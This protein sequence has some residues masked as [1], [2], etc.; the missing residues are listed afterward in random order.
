MNN[1]D[2][3]VKQAIK[4]SQSA[5]EDLRGKIESVLW[6]LDQADNTLK[7][8]TA[9]QNELRN[10]GA[11]NASNQNVADEFIALINEASPK[12]EELFKRQQRELS[13]FKIVLFGR[14]GTGKSTLIEAFVGGNGNT[15][16]FGDSDWTTQIA[17]EKWNSCVFV[18]TPGVCGWGRTN[19]REELEQ[20]AQH[21]VETADLV[22]LCFDSQNQT[23]SEFNKVADW[24]QKYGKP[25]VVVFNSRNRVWRMPHHKAATTVQQRKNI[26]QQVREQTDNIRD[27]LENMRLFDIPIVA[28]SSQRALYARIKEPFDGPYQ[29]NYKEEVVRYRKQYGLENLEKWSNFPTLEKLIIEAISSNA[30]GL[31]LGMLQEQTRGVLHSIN[32]DLCLLQQE[33]QK[34]SNFFEGYIK[35]NLNIVGDPNSRQSFPKEPDGKVDLLTK[36]EQLRQEP[37][38]ARIEGEYQVHA[39]RLL[40]AMLEPLRSESQS[41][42]QQLVLDAFDNGQQLSEEDVKNRVFDSEAIKQAANSIVQEAEEYLQRKLKLE[43]KETELDVKYITR[44]INKVNGNKNTGWQWVN[45]AAMGGSFLGSMVYVLGCLALGNFWNPLGWTA[46]VATGVSVIS[47]LASLAFSL[48][49]NY[50]NKQVEKTRLSKRREALSQLLQ[51]VN[52]SYDTLTQKIVE[53]TS[54]LGQKA[55]VETLDPLLRDAIALRLIQQETQSTEAYLINIINEIPS[56]ISAQK[57]L[58]DAANS[59]EQKCFPNISAPGL[60]LWLGEDWISD[61]IGLKPE[62]RT[63]GKNVSNPI[64]W[65]KNI[66]KEQPF[67]A[68]FS[69]IADYGNSLQPGT[70]ARWLNETRQILTPA[71]D[72]IAKLFNELDIFSKDQKAR[73]HLYGDYNTGK[74]SFIKRLLINAGLDIPE[75]LEVRGNPTTTVVDKYE[76]EGIWLVDNPGFQSTRA[77]DTDVALDSVADASAIIYLFNPNLITGDSNTID[78]VLKGDEKRG[79]LP[80]TDRTFFIINRCDELGVDPTESPKE[81]SR[82]CQRKKEELVLA[83][84]SRGIFITIQQVFCMSSDPYGL[85]GNRRDVNSKDFDSYRDWDGFDSFVNAF[86]SKRSEIKKMGADW[87][88]LEAAV[89]RFSKLITRVTEAEEN[90]EKKDRLINHMCQILS[91]AIG[92][93]DRIE[94]EIKRELRLRIVKDHTDGLVKDTLSAVGEAQIQ[95]QAK[96]LSQWWKDDAFQNEFKQWYKKAQNQIS[97]LVK[98]TED[99][100]ERRIYSAEFENTFPEIANNSNTIDNPLPAQNSWLNGLTTF[101]RKTSRTIVPF[102]DNVATGIVEILEL[103]P[104]LAPKIAQAIPLVTIFS[105]GIEVITQVNDETKRKKRENSRKN[106]IAKIEQSREEFCRLW[107]EETE[108]PNENHISERH[109]NIRLPI[110]YLREIRDVLESRLTEYKTELEN[111]KKDREDNN[112]RKQKYEYCKNTAWRLLTDQSF[113]FQYFRQQ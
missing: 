84:N 98:N 49:R 83:L 42:A 15:V 67:K 64:T 92:N 77:N 25:V 88:I 17:S 78:L 38:Q 12:I 89:A 75:N 101:I 91:E 16:S 111:T 21:A 24:I 74:T 30:V 52:E 44:P 60:K 96:L 35:R 14:T 39:K 40:S 99:L 22:L 1:L 108:R 107:L 81:Y 2:Y 4:E 105:L 87:L 3:A 28:L 33:A 95:A 54:K 63:D 50:A 71:D 56:R 31:R 58:L 32:N 113:R 53:E 66:L 85:V 46:A 51:T 86:V 57:L 103:S 8:W 9:A 61:S 93:A 19:S 97:H 11:E 48:L 112:A 59:V 72:E 13:T 76:W 70:A 43:R 104:R 79:I 102:S 41:K 7:P 47:P 90:L 55:L 68:K 82:L 109:T 62:G 110:G 29:E 27:E 94:A 45:Y 23:A 26:S 36:L 10:K 73:L 80:K 100:M 34:A 37:F 18:D 20:K 5:F 69:Q 106:L 65:V 6:R